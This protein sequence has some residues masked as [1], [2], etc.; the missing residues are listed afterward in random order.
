MFLLFL[1][2]GLLGWEAAGR[3]AMST[4]PTPS[5]FLRAVWVVASGRSI[6]DKPSDEDLARMA[7]RALP[8]VMYGLKPDWERRN[9]DGR[10]R[11]SNSL[12]FRGP[13]VEVP[14]P[15]GRFRIVCLGG[16]TTY[17][18]GV[19]DEDAYPLLLEKL[20]RKARPD[21]DIEVVNAGVPSYTSAESLANLAFRCLDL[22]PDAIVVYQG[23]NDYRPRVYKNFDSAY[24][25]WRKVWDGTAHGWEAGEG[26]MEGGINP[27][28]QHN[29][30]EDN[31]SHEQNA[32]R[33][34]TG[35][36]RRNLISIAGIAAAH[37]VRTVFVSTTC[38]KNS[39]FDLEVMVRFI[40][41]HNRVM[42]EVATDQGA[43]F[44]DLAP[45]FPQAGTFHD[46]VHLN[47]RGTAIKARI[48]AD[49]LLESLW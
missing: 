33:A 5:K 41:E 45:E 48:I 30:P 24:F 35:A 1:F 46:P 21:L 10:A 32:V 6:A 34:G 17:S 37:G 47:P 22:E 25:H 38:D 4:A 7:Y 12:G 36:Y 42:S 13:D 31:G 3:I 27:L 9:V 44:I 43:I 40:A 29:P 11:T 28:I 39:T 20:L 19:G 16:S 26:E 23:V 14:K 2:V 15:L 8:Y 49:G 18:D